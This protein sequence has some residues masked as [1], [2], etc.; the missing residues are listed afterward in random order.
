MVLYFS[1]IAAII[2]TIARARQRGIP[3]EDIRSFPSQWFNWVFFGR[4]FSEPFSAYVGSRIE[5]KRNPQ[6]FWLLLGI[7]L[8]IVFWIKERNHC[9]ESAKRWEKSLW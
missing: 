3:W 9:A 2:C 8:D 4:D 6:F 7:L 1:V 5:Y